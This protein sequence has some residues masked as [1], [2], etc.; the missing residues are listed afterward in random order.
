MYKGESLIYFGF[1]RSASESNSFLRRQLEVLHMQVISITT[2]SLIN[3][4]KFNPSF[5][6]VTDIYEHAA[7]LHN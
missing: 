4:L 6:V 1:T 2:I 3:T 5:D 7:L